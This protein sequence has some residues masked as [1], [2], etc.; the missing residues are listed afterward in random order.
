[1]SLIVE[2]L[3]IEENIK[4]VQN[5]KLNDLKYLNALSEYIGVKD[6]RSL[7]KVLNVTNKKDSHNKLKEILIK[8]YA[9][10]SDD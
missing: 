4:T 10:P 6:P 9:V 2:W 5:A 3:K 7:A 8:M 1:M